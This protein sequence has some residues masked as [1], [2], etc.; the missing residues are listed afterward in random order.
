MTKR[1][2][3]EPRWTAFLGQFLGKP[4]VVRLAAAALLVAGSVAVHAQQA[5]KVYR[6]GFV[7]AASP[8]PSNPQFD[9]FRQGLR[10]LGYVE[11]KNV[12]VEARFAEGLERLP[13]LATELIRLKVD[14]L[15][16]GSPAGAM[17]AKKA[18]A[19]VPIVFAGVGD[20]VTSGIV[21]SLARP[22]GNITGVA[23]GVGGPA[24]GEKWLELLKE[25]L[26]GVSQVAVLAN[27][28]N[29]SNSPYL[30]GVEAAARTLKVKLDILDAGNATEL[31]RALAAIGASGAQ[32]IIVTNDR[33][34]CSVS[35]TLF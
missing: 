21:A 33:A 14:V 25:A 28:S 16:A 13:E 34:S 26:P 29:P 3:F 17:A 24:F 19:T 7:S 15:M 30:E 2:P 1:D 31:D 12:I 18:S 22:G 5:A 35:R 32:A 27:R 4:I 8:N 6:I 10:E 20:P 23:S 9:A 11:G